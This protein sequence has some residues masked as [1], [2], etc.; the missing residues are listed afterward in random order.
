M[1]S[2]CSAPQALRA[3]RLYSLALG[4]A[5]SPPYL[6]YCKLF[7]VTHLAAFRFTSRIKLDGFREDINFFLQ[8]VR[9]A[10]WLGQGALASSFYEDSRRL[11]GG[12]N[13]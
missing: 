7:Q 13:T 1:C 9:N 5:V 10:L 4:A 3:W 6:G 11:L 8:G 2:P 12:T